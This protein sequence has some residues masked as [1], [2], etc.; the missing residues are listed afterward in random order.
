LVPVSCSFFPIFNPEIA[1]LVPTFFKPASTYGIAVLTAVFPRF[2]KPVLISV[3][4]VSSTDLVFLPSEVPISP[5]NL[6]SFSP[7][8]SKE[9]A[10]IIPRTDYA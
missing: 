3:F 9:D 4:V 10:I 7:S 6:S 8:L 1:T 2:F 5:K